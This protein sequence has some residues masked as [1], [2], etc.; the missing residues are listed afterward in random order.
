MFFSFP[1]RFNM[2]VVSTDYLQ[3]DIKGRKTFLFKLANTIASDYYS[4]LSSEYYNNYYILLCGYN[5]FDRFP[6]SFNS[7]NVIQRCCDITSV[8]SQ[9]RY[10]IKFKQFADDVRSLIKVGCHMEEQEYGTF[11][12]IWTRVNIKSDETERGWPKFLNIVRP[13]RYIVCISSLVGFQ[14]F[15]KT[16]QASAMAYTIIQ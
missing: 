15:L 11:K 8:T 1:R 16:S 6:A 2:D 9:E 12:H 14:G 13:G 7:Q 4:I 3:Q 5:T 10:K